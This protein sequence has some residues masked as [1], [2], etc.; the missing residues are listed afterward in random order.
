ML[1]LR[2]DMQCPLVSKLIPRFKRRYNVKS[3]KHP[4]ENVNSSIK[5]PQFLSLKGKKIYV[6]FCWFAS[7]FFFLLLYSLL[8][9]NCI[10]HWKPSTTI[11]VIEEEKQT[12]TVPILTCVQ[13]VKLEWENLSSKNWAANWSWLPS[14]IRRY[15]K[16]K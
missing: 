15:L 5:V 10:C 9:S 12:R 7:K 2:L 4:S 16:F 1:V 11:R 3:V 14:G 8:F 13:K 6:F